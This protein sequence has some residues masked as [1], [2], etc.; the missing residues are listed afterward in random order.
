MTLSNDPVQ[1]PAAYDPTASK[2]FLRMKVLEDWIDRIFDTSPLGILRVDLNFGITYANRKAMEI[3]GVD[4]WQKRNVLEFVP[5]P[6]TVGLWKEKLADRQRGLSEEYE[7][8][9]VRESDG[10]RIPV[11]VASMP[12]LDPSGN[13][14]GAVSILR[15]LEVEKASKAIDRCVQI[16]RTSEALLQAVAEHTKQVVPF[17]ACSVTIYSADMQHARMLFTNS[18][19]LASQQSSRW[20]QMTPLLRAWA[21]NTETVIVPDAAEFIRS[22]D[23]DQEYI[24]RALENLREAGWSSFIRYPVVREGRVIG[25][26]VLSSK[27]PGGFGNDDRKKL[28][29]LP[30][31]VALGTALHYEEVSELEFRLGLVR[32]VLR[33]TDNASLF[34][35]LVN[36]LAA[37][38][39]WN[40]VSVFKVN[41]ERETIALQTQVSRAGKLA[42]PADYEQG[43]DD[44]ILGYVRRTGAEVN[45]G[46]VE[47]NPRFKKLFLRVNPSTVSELCMP[48]NVEGAVYAL[49]N[50][51]DSKEDAFAP[52]EVDALKLVLREVEAVIERFRSAQLI[53]A[54]YDATPTAVWVVDSKGR[55]KKANP[56]A[57]S[58]V[59]IQEEILVGTSL[60][61]FFQDPELGRAVLKAH[62]PVS[63][64]VTLL[65]QSGT[66]VN[67]L[68]GGS[69]LEKEFAGE[70]VITARDLRG[71]KRV[72]EIE[73]LDQLYYE[74]ATQVK[75]PLALSCSWLQRL[76]ASVDASAQEVL[77]KA[78]RQLQKVEITYD[79]LALFKSNQEV[80]P[81]HE[82][83]LDLGRLLRACV[84]ELPATDCIVC[85][86]LD[87][88]APLIPADPFQLSFVFKSILS[89]LMRFE[90][91]PGQIHASMTVDGA[92]FSVTISGPYV[93]GNTARRLRRKSDEALVR[94]LSEMALG[95]QVIRKFISNHKGKYYE[96]E[97]KPD[98]IVFRIEL[99]FPAEGKEYESVGQ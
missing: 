23:F 68:L 81:Y 25:S 95:E 67:V 76:K 66:P 87:S 3:C 54:T 77:D 72:E 70:R 59:G 12:A 63:R 16:S 32:D 5:D 60:A 2:V 40:S 47:K 65:H 31:E 24:K 39:G 94:T 1:I 43:I 89:Y 51:E 64:E 80:T 84:D 19:E 99:P 52:E 62:E 58:L 96:P 56:A 49:L 93:A 92:M 20:F 26:F 75:T 9:V 69:Q 71:H 83:P 35:L 53:T 78:L 44:G 50:I 7:T 91:E 13:V 90:T 37:H 48:I 22:M 74:I 18:P 79:R 4:R 42:I 28:E 36:R 38:Y 85:E 15:T 8:E 10:Q 27:V 82:V 73:M 61:K 55:I 14:V 30:L 88:A 46:N 45:I 34:S 97:I 29:A 41:E 6:A 98:L 57:Q 86:G 33:C 21:Q 11:K 17:D